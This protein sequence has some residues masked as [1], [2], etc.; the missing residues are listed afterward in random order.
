MVLS[1]VAERALDP[2]DL[3]AVEA[4]EAANLDNLNGEFDLAS[5]VGFPAKEWLRLR[6]RL[7]LRLIL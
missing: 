4:S 5:E 6:L 7:R 2:L 3:Q 1:P